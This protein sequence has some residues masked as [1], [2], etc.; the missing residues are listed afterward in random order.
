MGRFE[1]PAKLPD[2][3]IVNALVDT[4]STFSKLPGETLRSL[5]VTSSFTGRVK[6]GDGRLVERQVGYFTLGLDGRSAPVPVMFAEA[7]ETPLIGATTLEILGFT[8]DPV[9]KR[10]VETPYL[11]LQ[12]TERSF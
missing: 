9:G 12:T 10:L 3:T 5:G 2:G 4:G 7:G 6:L 11:E 8:V 1:I